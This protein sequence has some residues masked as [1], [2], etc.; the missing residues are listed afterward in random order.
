M[1]RLFFLC[2][3][4]FVVFSCE[5]AENRQCF[6]TAGDPSERVVIPP[7]FNKL[8]INEHVI[9]VLVQD[10]VEKIVLTGGKNLL[11][12]IDV[13]MIDGV[14]EISNSNTCNFLRSYKKKVTAEIHF[15]SLINLHFEGTETLSN[16]GLLYMDWLTLLIRD[17]AGPVNLNVNAELIDATVAHGWGDFTLTGSTGKAIFNVNSNGYCDTY[18]LQVT[19]SI[20]VVS[21]T[22]GSLKVNANGIKLKAQTE[23]N[24]NIYYKGVP[25]IIEFNRYGAGDLIDD[26]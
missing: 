22:Q 4:A 2:S 3:F 23:T 24:G 12:F 21:N 8:K 10:S 9:V 13:E 6:K 16:K 19:D 25:S 17:G 1:M 18:G 11:N 7:S 15:K 14:L 5:K 20:T 26:N